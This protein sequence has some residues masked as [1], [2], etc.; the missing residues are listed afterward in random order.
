M[1]NVFFN[2][3]IKSWYTCGGQN[4]EFGA[5]SQADFNNQSLVLSVAQAKI[6]LYSFKSDCFVFI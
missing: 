5:A 2:R 1:D 3:P 6:R 4:K